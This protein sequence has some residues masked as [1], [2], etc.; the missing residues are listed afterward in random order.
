MAAVGALSALGGDLA[1]SVS[2]GIASELL[3][4]AN[5]AGLSEDELISTVLSIAVLFSAVPSS[6]RAVVSH[7]G[8]RGSGAAAGAP[9]SAVT[10]FF[11]LLLSIGRRI[12][13][14]ICIQLL[15]SNVRARQPLRSVRIMS[16]L[17]ISVF[18]IFLE[19]GSGV[20]RATR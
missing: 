18:F 10:E 4:A 5:E 9:V 15:S 20:G 6:L 13:L 14:S 2:F 8:A 17:A 7:L 12:S 19:S 11:A 1:F 3:E 16:L